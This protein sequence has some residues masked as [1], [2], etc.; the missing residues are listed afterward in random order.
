MYVNF[1]NTLTQCYKYRSA[2]FALLRI[3]E[4]R[5]TVHILESSY[6]QVHVIMTQQRYCTHCFRSSPLDA[7]YIHELRQRWKDLCTNRI[8]KALEGPEEDELQSLEAILADEEKLRLR[9][10]LE[11]AGLNF[12][13]TNYLVRLDFLDNAPSDT[14]PLLQSRV[15]RERVMYQAQQEFFKEKERND[16]GDKERTNHFVR[17]SRQNHRWPSGGDRYG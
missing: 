16:D 12:N 8:D 10:D 2:I 13:D 14:Y 7:V 9:S 15:A 5:R 3:Q 1:L 4:H 11:K 6:P 17:K